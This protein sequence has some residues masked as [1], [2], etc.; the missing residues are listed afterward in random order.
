MNDKIS[1]RDEVG[2]IKFTGGVDRSLSQERHKSMDFS[3][4]GIYSPMKKICC[5]PAFTNKP[6]LSRLD[7]PRKCFSTG[8]RVRVKVRLLANR[9]D[10]VTLAFTVV[11][12]NKV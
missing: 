2:I 12:T 6:R 11:V 10:S 9:H 4:K 8:G 3:D 7:S 5:P 1:I